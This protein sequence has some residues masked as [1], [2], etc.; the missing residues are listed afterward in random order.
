VTKTSAKPEKNDATTALSTES[1]TNLL[2]ISQEYDHEKSSN[3]GTASVASSH[4]K[5]T[6]SAQSKSFSSEFFPSVVFE[7]HELFS[8]VMKMGSLIETKAEKVE[9]IDQESPVA[10]EVEL[11]SKSPAQPHISAISNVS[12]ETLVVEASTQ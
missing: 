10:A 12:T 6:Y 7:N 9:K 8:D 5:D 2:H 4:E 1:T 11:S 3:E